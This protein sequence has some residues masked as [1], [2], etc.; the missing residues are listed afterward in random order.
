MELRAK[1]ADAGGTQRFVMMR[2]GARWFIW[3]VVKPWFW[4]TN[5][6]LGQKPGT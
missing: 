5:M 3:G 1:I 4:W 6:A 2:S